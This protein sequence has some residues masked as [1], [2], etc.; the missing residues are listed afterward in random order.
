MAKKKKHRKNKPHGHYCKVC[1][2]HK[3]NEKFSGKGHAAHICKKCSAL[4]VAERNEQMMVNKISGMAFRYLSKTEIK[5]LRGKMNDAR[6]EV[7]DAAREAYNMKFPNYDRELEKLTALKTPV[8]LSELNDEQK[9][10]A[11]ERLEELIEGFFM[12]ADYI[13]D[14]ALKAAFDGIIAEIVA[15]LKADGVE[16]PTFMDTLLVTETERLIIRRFYGKDTDALWKIIRKPEVMYAWESGFKKSEVRKWLNRQLT[17]YHKDGYGY[18]AVTLKDSGK[19]I[20]QAG[21]MNLNLNGETVVEIGYIFDNTAWGQ[22]YAIEAARAC[23][24]LAFGQFGLDR[25]YATVR[26]ENAASV[27]LVEKL[28]MRKIG[29]FVKTYKDIEMPHDIYLLEKE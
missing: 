3:A 27:R 5:W 7:R 28:G 4:P 25:L 29:A 11:I 12:G 18:F 14:D 15:E 9:E 26:P 10:E 1:G 19:L 8:L 20:G 21:L 16:L 23:V 6:P 22:G 17:R 2:E 24:D 13:P